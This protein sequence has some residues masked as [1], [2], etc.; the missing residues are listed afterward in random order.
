[1]RNNGGRVR[2][3]ARDATR[4]GWAWQEM[5]TL[6]DEKGRNFLTVVCTRSVPGTNFLSEAFYRGAYDMVADPSN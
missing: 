5:L 3:P 4:P 6:P 1:M 2:G